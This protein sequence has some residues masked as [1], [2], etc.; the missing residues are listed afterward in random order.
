MVLYFLMIYP[1]ESPLP[2]IEEV[3]KIVQQKELTF[4]SLKKNHQSL[5]QAS[6]G[7]LL[8]QFFAFYGTCSPHGFQPFHSIVSLR[9]TF[10]VYKKSSS[11]HTGARA[12]SVGDVLEDHLGILKAANAART[13]LIGEVDTSRIETNDISNMVVYSLSPSWRFCIEDPYEEHDLGKVIFSLTGQIHI[14]DELKR[15][16]TLFNDLVVKH[17][18]HVRD[19]CGDSIVPSTFDF[20]LLLS[21]VNQ[22]VPLA[23]KTCSICGQEG[24]FSKECDFLRCHLCGERG[25]FMKDCLR[26]FCS[27]CR[28][29]GHFA[30]DCTKERICRYCKQPGHEVKDCPT[31][32]CSRC[33]SKNH[34]THRCKYKSTELHASSAVGKSEQMTEEPPQS[35]SSEQKITS[36]VFSNPDV[37]KSLPRSGRVP[38]LP[39]EA[40]KNSLAK[41]SRVGASIKIVPPDSPVM[42]SPNEALDSPLPPSESKVSN[43]TQYL[44][45][46]E[47][48]CSPELQRP[49]IKESRKKKKRKPRMS[50]TDSIGDRSE[51]VPSSDSTGLDQ[52]TGNLLLANTSSTSSSP[53][54]MKENR[55][56]SGLTSERTHAIRNP[57]SHVACPEDKKEMKSSLDFETNHSIASPGDCKFQA[58]ET[59]PADHKMSAP[60]LNSMKRR[61]AQ[62]KVVQH[63]DSHESKYIA[64]SRPPGLLLTHRSRIDASCSELSDFAMDS[65]TQH[66]TKMLI[67]EMKKSK[68]ESREVHARGVQKPILAA[69][70]SPEEFIPCKRVIVKRESKIIESK[71][72][73]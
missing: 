4:E 46:A 60:K 7:K 13:E 59:L 43:D 25:H 53:K 40:K 56:I 49:E 9:N 35:I 54:E 14:M 29:Q 22:S 21:H 23:M 42:L 45:V 64:P 15:C 72:D 3:G 71:I 33:G 48:M 41:L 63:A 32:S 26:L 2:S 10:R 65:P 5:H 50:Q 18:F 39:F 62:N 38:P 47:E 44:P 12:K 11:L 28:K 27:N 37:P 70:N 36:A 19:F 30:K 20:W 17:R 24:H 69:S 58:L 55:N 51:V 31:K 73:G 61:K 16:L 8:I 68:H 34:T 1:T 66:E 57:T 6:F 52:H 67:E